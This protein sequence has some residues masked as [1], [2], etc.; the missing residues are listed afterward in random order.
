MT[1]AFSLLIAGVQVAGSGI[2]AEEQ[3][4]EGRQGAYLGTSA[5]GSEETSLEGGWPERL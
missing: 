3:E 2:E 4:A 1:L 5:E